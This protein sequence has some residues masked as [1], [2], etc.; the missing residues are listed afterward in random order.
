VF[1]DS[2]GNIYT[3]C[4]VDHRCILIDTFGI[5]HTI[6]GTGVSGFTGDG[7]LATNAKMWYP[8]DIKLDNFGHIYISDW[9]NSRIRRITYPY[10]PPTSSI[11]LSGVTST[12]VG[13]SVTITATLTSVGSTYT[14]HWLNHGIEFTTTSVPSVTYIKPLGIDTITAWIDP[15][16]FYDSAMAAGHVVGVD[17]LGMQTQ[18]NSDG[19][20]IYPNPTTNLLHIT[21][22]PGAATY[23][24]LSMVGAVVQCGQLPAGGGTAGLQGLPP[25]MYV[26]ELVT[27]RG[28]RVMRRVVKE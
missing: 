3:A 4:N 14:L 25:G 26:L 21:G 27:E 5:T 8:R 11:A 22:L 28:E 1:I 20:T 17:A 6:A 15:C 13:S 12:P 23:R 18:V 10:T 7:G 16:G 24:L 19:I 2:I 9:N